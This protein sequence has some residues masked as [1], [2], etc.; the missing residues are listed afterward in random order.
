MGGIALHRLHQIGDQVVALLKLDVDVGKGLIGSLPHGDQ[1][2]I[3][4]DGP[5]HDDDNDAENDPAGGGHETAPDKKVERN[6]PSLDG[7]FAA[8][9]N[10]VG[11]DRPAAWPR[12]GS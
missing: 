10:P 9:G 4:T 7:S 8:N 3:D 12:L 11:L 1:V 5:D 6:K 2:V